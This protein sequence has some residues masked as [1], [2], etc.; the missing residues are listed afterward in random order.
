[1]NPVV[2]LFPVY[3]S[4]SSSS[5]DVIVKVARKPSCMFLSSAIKRVLCI[6]RLISVSTL[7]RAVDTRIAVMIAMMHSF[8]IARSK[9]ARKRVLA[10]YIVSKD[11]AA[12]T[13]NEYVTVMKVMQGVL[14]WVLASADT[15]LERKNTE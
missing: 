7:A 10:V 15:T 12:I 13:C 4:S 1:M 5:S 11:T 2:A 8:P 6:L 3:N 14:C 9:S